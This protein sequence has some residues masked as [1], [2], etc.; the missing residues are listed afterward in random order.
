MGNSC[1]HEHEE[2][3]EED[4]FYMYLLYPEERKIF[5]KIHLVLV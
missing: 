2:E 4:T 5:V 3:I 1:N